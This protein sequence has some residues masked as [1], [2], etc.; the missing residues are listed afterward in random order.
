MVGSARRAFPLTTLR[1]SAATRSEVA[2]DLA[3]SHRTSHTASTARIAT[4]I[5]IRRELLDAAGGGA[6]PPGTG[7]APG[8]V[9]PTN[10]VELGQ[11]L[12]VGDGA[13]L[14]V[15][16]HDHESRGVDPGG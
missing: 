14:A 16:G 9:K 10:H 11:D 2:W 8:S 7:A 4:T 13:G 6:A 5:R 1:I 3:L 15:R 12:D